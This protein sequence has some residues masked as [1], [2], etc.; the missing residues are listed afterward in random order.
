M[1]LMSTMMS[2][3]NGMFAMRSL[4]VDALSVNALSV[5]EIVAVKL[6]RR[7]QS[8]FTLIM[9][10]ETAPSTLHRGSLLLTHDSVFKY[11]PD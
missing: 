8:Q 1:F 6:E 7:V 2:S 11:T 3:V 5:G 4:H 10:H 9:L